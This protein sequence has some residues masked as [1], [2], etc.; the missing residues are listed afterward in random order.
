VGS[1]YPIPCPAGTYQDERGNNTCKACLVGHYCEVET[2]TPVKCPVG[3]SCPAG[4]RS[5][6]EFP[7]PRGPSRTA[8]VKTFVMRAPVVATVPFIFGS[9]L[10]EIFVQALVC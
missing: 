5:L 8:L 3:R 4:T 6:F 1:D 9:A 10:L 7:C 2:T